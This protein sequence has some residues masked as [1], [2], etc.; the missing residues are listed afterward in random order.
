MYSLQEIR[1]NLTRE[2]N[3]FN[4]PVNA[5]TRSRVYLAVGAIFTLSLVTIYSTCREKIHLGFKHIYHPIRKNTRLKVF[6]V[7]SLI[8]SLFLGTTFSVFNGLACMGIC[9][10]ATGIVVSNKKKKAPPL[11]PRPKRSYGKKRSLSPAFQREGKHNSTDT[12]SAHKQPFNYCFSSITDVHPRDEHDLSQ[13]ERKALECIRNAMGNNTRS[14]GGIGAIEVLKSKMSSEMSYAEFFQIFEAQMEVLKD[15]NTFEPEVVDKIIKDGECNFIFQ[16]IDERQA[17]AK[18]FEK[19]R[20]SIKTEN[21]S[22]SEDS[23]DRIANLKKK[24]EELKQEMKDLIKTISGNKSADTLS[25]TITFKQ[26]EVLSKI[27]DLHL[28]TGS[29]ESYLND[30]YLKVHRIDETS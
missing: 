18:E 22:M 13:K 15:S 8:F 30:N 12:N 9:L 6:L 29:Y 7:V 28:R 14:S 3:N 19:I 16:I 4:S 21:V 24:R 1:Y 2:F 10:L 5:D 23:I 17:L 25:L 11:P 20:S 26:S 27:T